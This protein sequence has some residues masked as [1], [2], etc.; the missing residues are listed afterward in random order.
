[1]KAAVV[2]ILQKTARSAVF[3]ARYRKN[4]AKVRIQHKRNRKR[5]RGECLK[6]GLYIER[7][8]HR[9]KKFVV[10]PS[11]FTYLF[12][13]MHRVG[14]GGNLLLPHS[15]VYKKRVPKQ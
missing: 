14:A 13:Q 8:R 7:G 6:S 4:P 11:E 3:G 5:R 10:K 2:P 9:S 1:M 15:V 12:T